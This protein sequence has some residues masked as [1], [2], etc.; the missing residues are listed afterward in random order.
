MTVLCLSII[1]CGLLL[2][3]G[4]GDK[5]TEEDAWLSFQIAMN[6]IFG[7]G[8]WKSGS[9]SYQDSTLSVKDLSA[10]LKISSPSINST[11]PLTVKN[12]SVKDIISSKDMKELLDGESWKGKSDLTL[13]QNLTLDGVHLETSEDTS[14]ISLDLDKGNLIKVVLKAAKGSTLPGAAGYL[15]HLELDSYEFLNIAL[16]FQDSD[17]ESGPAKFIA[18]QEKLSAKGVSFSGSPVLEDQSLIDVVLGK[19]AKEISADGLKVELAAGALLGSSLEVS[20]SLVRDMMGVAQSSHSSVKGIKFTA[21]LPDDGENFR[22]VAIDIDEV[23]VDGYEGLEFMQ[24]AIQELQ[25]IQDLEQMGGDIYSDDNADNMLEPRSLA[26]VFTYP[27]S[28]EKASVLGVKMTMDSLNFGLDKAEYLGPVKRHV[29]PSFKISLD[30]LNAKLDPSNLKGEMQENIVA[31]TQTLGTQ[32]LRL[33]AKLSSQYDPTKGTILY[34]YETIDLKDLAS[35]KFVFG[36]AG[37]T[38]A[39]VEQLTRVGFDDIHSLILVPGFSDFGL[40]EL[41]LDYTDKSLVPKLIQ[42]TAQNAGI[43]AQQITAGLKFLLGS[44]ISGILDPELYPKANSAV[45]GAVNNFLDNPKSLSIS[46]KPKVPLSMGNAFT[47]YLRGE[48]GIR[49]LFNNLNISISANGQS[50]EAVLLD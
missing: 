7:E 26:E 3:A 30:N 46:V 41:I 17:E 5:K 9:H 25:E 47:Y 31:F 42:K 4:C 37:L 45:M 24:T 39:L 10:S 49:E 22:K 16:N 8:A 43:P 35:L 32:D 21:D 11:I 33:D 15:R 6:K 44:K 27:Y 36:L 1:L 19:C 2:L 18:S 38:P 23:S 50:Q 20:Q 40:N 34:N 14:K 29:V 28:F 13:A 48:S 12:I